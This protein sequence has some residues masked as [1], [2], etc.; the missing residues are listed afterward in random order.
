MNWWL[1][2]CWDNLIGSCEKV[3]RFEESLIS[4]WKENDKNEMINRKKTT[5]TTYSLHWEFFFLGKSNWNKNML[6][7]SKAVQNFGHLPAEVRG[8][9]WGPLSAWAYQMCAL[10][11]SI[12]LKQHCA[13]RPWLVSRKEMR[14]TKRR[15]INCDP[16]SLISCYE[17]PEHPSEIPC[18]GTT[19]Q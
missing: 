8:N 18:F 12:P 1:I 19:Y 16:S 6:T 4:N 15:K 2:F 9:S 17:Q 7:V 14:L 5:T 10:C 3:A 13:T 11:I